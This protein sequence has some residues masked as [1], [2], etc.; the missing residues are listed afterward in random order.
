MEFVHFDSEKTPFRLQRSHLRFPLP[1]K[2][3]RGFRVDQPSSWPSVEG[4]LEFVQGELR[5]MPPCA[6]YQQDVAA[7]VVGLLWKWVAKH[8]E[9]IVAANEAGMMLGGEAR[10][11]DAAVWRKQEAGT[12]RGTFRRVPP[13]LA[14]EVAG[15]D[16]GEGSLREK[17][18]WYI[19]HGVRYV[20]LLFP[21]TRTALVLTA[22]GEQ[23]LKGRSR[24]AAAPEL[25]GL[26]LTAQ[27]L[28]SQL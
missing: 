8:S 5:Y 27:S 10:G 20:W 9:F 19:S 17:A 12:H 6:D 22:D 16:E 23:R 11:A 14:V 15:E 1:L 25:P 18:A 3:P 2:V 13:I 7:T 26:R 21:R 24:F 28:F 4:R